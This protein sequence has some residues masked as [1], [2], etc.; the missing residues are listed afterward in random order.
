[1]LT[2]TT[3]FSNALAAFHAG[4]IDVAIE[5]E[6]YSR[7]F[8]NRDT[9]TSGQVPWLVS[10]DDYAYTIKDTEGGADQGNLSFNVQ[11]FDNFITADFPNFVF[12]G[13][14]VTVKVGL[15]G[16]AYSD[17]CVVFAGYIDSVNSQNNNLEYQ[18]SC[19]DVTGYLSAVV[20]QLGDDGLPTSQTNFKTLNA[21]PLD[22]MLDILLNQLKIDSSLVDSDTIQAFRDGPYAGI[23]FTFYLQQPVAAADF[24]LNQLLKPLGA[25]MF[26]SNGRIT[27]SSFFPIAVPTPVATLGPDNWTS[28]PSAEQTGSQTSSNPL[29][30]YVQWQFDKD[31]FGLSGGYNSSDVQQFAPSLARYG[32]NNVGELTVTAD[33]LRSAFLGFFIAASVSHMMFLQYGFK[34]LLFDSNS[35]D[36]QWNTLLLE[37]GDFVFVTHLDVPD[38]VTG[39]MGIVDK[40]FRIKNKT[41]NFKEGLLTFTLI[42]ASYLANLGFYKI[43]EAYNPDGATAT[44]VPPYASATTAQKAKYMFLC[45]AAGQY[46]NGDEGHILG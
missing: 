29:I 3:N 5:I 31:D 38:R 8:V 21:H 14:T 4:H 6:G 39:D 42:D 1:M 26:V 16:L 13:K 9:G 30:N 19:L 18:F 35:A 37:S 36:S 17:W 45:N 10:V 23:Q 22:L 12:E 41:I 43:A 25:Y 28:I 2:A 44:P 27:M 40:L 24:I 32:V 15:P 34:T 33:G 11:D 7:V 20:Y 46:S